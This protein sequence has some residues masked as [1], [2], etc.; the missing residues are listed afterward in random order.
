MAV[1]VEEQTWTKTVKATFVNRPSI[2][3]NPAASPVPDF[4]NFGVMLRIL[5]GV[6]L[7]AAA[8]RRYGGL[9][10]AFASA[11]SFIVSFV[12]TGFAEDSKGI[13]SGG[14]GVSGRHVVGMADRFLALHGGVG[15]WLATSVAGGAFKWRGGWK[16]AVLFF[17]TFSGLVSGLERGAFASSDG[18]YSSALFVQ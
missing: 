7:L 14:G 18:T 3:Q 5:L 11:Q 8:L 2:K 16:H 13:G 6:N 9:G 17:L 12:G 1:G 15:R 10:A 4:R